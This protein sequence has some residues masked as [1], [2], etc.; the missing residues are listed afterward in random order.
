MGGATSAQRQKSKSERRRDTIPTA[1]GSNIAK[2]SNNATGQ[3][4]SG[5]GRILISKNRI[6]TG[7]KAQD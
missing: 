7:A 4:N 5:A 2:V 1:Q 3:Q 6:T